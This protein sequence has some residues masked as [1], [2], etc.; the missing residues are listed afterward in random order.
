MWGRNAIT[1]K[2][3]NFFVKLAGSHYPAPPT[4]DSEPPMRVSSSH[5]IIMFLVMTNSCSHHGV[6]TFLPHPS[7]LETIQQQANLALTNPVVD[8]RH[9]QCV[10][11]A[12]LSHPALRGRMHVLGGV[13]P[14]HPEV[15]P[16]AFGNHSIT[17]P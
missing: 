2:R 10:V 16:G 8:T 1:Q 17:P 14:Y 15:S 13:N 12:G 4:W 3:P 9:S 11:P 5:R 7:W 6:L